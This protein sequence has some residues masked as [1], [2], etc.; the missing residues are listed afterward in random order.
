MIKII[1]RGTRKTAICENCGCEFS[2][3]PEDI[4]RANNAGYVITKTSIE[5]RSAQNYV[6]CPQCKEEVIVEV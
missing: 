2:F 4:K 3:E 5:I 6:E 1:K